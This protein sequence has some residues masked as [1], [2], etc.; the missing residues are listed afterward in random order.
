MGLGV[1][2]REQVARATGEA[3]VVETMEFW[4]K[5]RKDRAGLAEALEILR[6]EAGFIT[7]GLCYHGK[8][9]LQVGVKSELCQNLPSGFGKSWEKP[10]EGLTGYSV[11]AQ[12]HVL[13]SLAV[14]LYFFGFIFF[15]ISVVLALVV[16]RGSR[17]SSP[18]VEL[19]RTH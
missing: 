17:I 8:K 19:R 9:L 3:Q 14:L 18:K 16:A 1:D 10:L 15:S 4:V 13:S 7:V 6:K 12:S 11:V 5:Q 2:L